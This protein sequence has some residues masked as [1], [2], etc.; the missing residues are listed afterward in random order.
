MGLSAVLR[1]FVNSFEAMLIAV[2][3]FGA[4]GSMI[5][6]GCP[7]TISLWFKG[8]SRGTAVG[9][10]MTGSWVGG[11]LALSITN[12]FV[13]PITGYS[14]R[15]TFV[16][17]GLLTFMTAFAWC[18]LGEDTK[19][20]IAEESASMREVFT[21]L[22]KVR[23]VKIVLFMAPLFLAITHG[24]TNWLPKIL[25]T[26]GLSPTTAGFVASI[27]V[28]AVIPSMLIIPRLVPL[29][30]RG[31]FVAFFAL[32]NTIALLVAVTASGALLIMGLILFGIAN[33]IL[34]L[35]LLIL[36]DIPEV[37][38]RYMGSA[39]GMFFCIGEIGGFTGPLIM[40]GL[41]NITGTF[42]TGGLFLAGLSIAM[43]FMIL[44]LKS[45]PV[46]DLR[47]S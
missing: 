6:I 13:M 24:L 38:S 32:L 31:R 21:Q 9:I 25:E 15:L 26:G 36:M 18:F 14:W 7:K 42:L 23:N 4:G 34:P 5:F 43:F 22:F 1:Y 20:T 46:S 41:V 47:T 19:P 37:N 17:Y 44:F 16:Y 30:L 40:G 3:L 10:Y 35:L 11:L 29:R 45:Q 39:G 33:S 8:R 12:S 2:A 28:A 27:P